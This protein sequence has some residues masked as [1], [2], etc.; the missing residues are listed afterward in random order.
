MICCS[1]RSTDRPP[2]KSEATHTPPIPST[3][4]SHA[5]IQLAEGTGLSVLSLI[6]GASLQRQVEAL[7]WEKPQVVIGA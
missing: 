7:R 1:D 3:N 6:G 2:K 4:Q 5:P